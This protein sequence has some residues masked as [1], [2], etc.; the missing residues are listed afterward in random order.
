MTYQNRVDAL[1]SIKASSLSNINSIIGAYTEIYMHDLN[2]KISGVQTAISNEIKASRKFSD[3]ERIS[4]KIHLAQLFNDYRSRHQSYQKEQFQELHE[5][6][7]EYGVSIPFGQLLFHG[8]SENQIVP[9]RPTSYSLLPHIAVYH[10][11]K[12]RNHEINGKPIYLYASRL[13]VPQG[14]TAAIDFT[15][16]DFRHELEVLLQANLKTECIQEK[17]I[18]EGVYVIDAEIKL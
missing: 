14:A 15:H 2:G 11:R 8:S 16:E 5:S 9:S 3:W 4:P 7:I 18:A 1:H 10:A 6:I 13:Q 12:H 17:E